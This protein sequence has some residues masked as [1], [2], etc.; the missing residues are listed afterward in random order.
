[1][2][3]TRLPPHPGPLPWGEGECY[4]VLGADLCTGHFPAERFH[5]PLSMGGEETPAAL[6]EI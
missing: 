3:S 6:G 2:F 1:M 4:A 5:S